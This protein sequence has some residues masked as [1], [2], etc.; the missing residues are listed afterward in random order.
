MVL[1]RI[2]IISI[3]LCLALA[4]ASATAAE[5][6]AALEQF[7]D[8]SFPDNSDI[9]AK[10]STRLITAPK[11]Q[12]WEFGSKVQSSKAGQVLVKSVKRSDDFLVQFVNGS[13]G[14]FADCSL[15]SYVIERNC[16]TGYIL[17]AKVFLE[18]DPSCYARLYPQGEGTKLDIVMYGAL[19]KK[20]LYISGLIY[21]VL[22]MPF[23]DIVDQTDRDF[24]WSTVFKLGRQSAT[25]GIVA[26]LRS[27]QAAP[28]PEAP[29]IELASMP[30][31]FSAVPAA[32][33]P[34]VSPPSSSERLVAAV[35]DSLSFE[36][37]V[38][39]LSV[40]GLSPTE[41]A[42]A[43]TALGLS[44]DKDP[45]VPAAYKPFP[46]Y[47]SDGGLPAAAV[48]GALYLASL[49]SPSSVYALIGAQGRIIAAPT[50]DEQGR[51]GFAF[52]SAGREI[53]WQDVKDDSLRVLRFEMRG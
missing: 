5:S 30:S 32:Q 1:K 31:P 14:Q 26:D 6:R 45:L 41:L 9:R 44:N 53:A 13:D 3:A 33:A 48:R 12:V 35:S 51:I 50:F 49:D 42:P 39:R 19:V 29:H 40:L 27:G 10:F 21:H 34:A 20:G 7:I 17:Q 11:E 15:G 23:S 18:D 2:T 52:F 24:D 25:A 37:L 22:T 47:A 8:H 38:S 28:Q 36:D 46:R 43:A 4:G 16:K